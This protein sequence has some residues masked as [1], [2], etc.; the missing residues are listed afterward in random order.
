MVEILRLADLSPQVLK[1]EI[2]CDRLVTY[3]S[4][5]LASDPQATGFGDFLPI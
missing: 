2:G 3:L 1:A 4:L 5:R